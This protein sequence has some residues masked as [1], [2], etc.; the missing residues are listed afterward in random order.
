MSTIASLVAKDILC[1]G[2]DDSVASAVRIMSERDVGAV[3]VMSEGRLEGIF[4]ERDVMKRVLAPGLDPHSTKLSEVASAQ[5][6][7]IG[8]SASVREC[9]YLVRDNNFRHLPVL[10][11]SGKVVGMISTRDFLKDLAAGFERVIQR[12]CA[13]S[14][15]PE[16]EDYY[17][18]VVG[19][20]V[21]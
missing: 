14:D 9:A 4:T 20:F 8:E 12:V 21:D 19:E 1:A 3:L 10:D 11:E 17:Q 16:C 13:T 7:T 15:A 2:P 18:N 5:P 6:M